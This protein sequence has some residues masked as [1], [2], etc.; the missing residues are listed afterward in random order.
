MEA[1]AGLRWAGLCVWWIL[2]DCVYLTKCPAVRAIDGR[3]KKKKIHTV[4]EREKKEKTA[5]CLVDG[6]NS[7]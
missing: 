1:S 7:P 5:A 3:R 6:L 4:N 2:T